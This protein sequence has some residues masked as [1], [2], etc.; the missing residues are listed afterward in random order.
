MFFKNISEFDG[1]YGLKEWVECANLWFQKRAKSEEECK[2]MF[3]TWIKNQI[4]G[5]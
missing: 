4:R 2:Q 5:T 3:R 1:Q